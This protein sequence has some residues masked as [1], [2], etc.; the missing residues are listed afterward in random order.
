VRLREIALVGG[1]LDQIYG[2]RGKELPMTAEWVF[3]GSED[4]PA[5]RYYPIG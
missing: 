1:G 5:I 4:G 3:V 2:K